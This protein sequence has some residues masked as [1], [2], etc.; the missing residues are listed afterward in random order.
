MEI[1][2]LSNRVIGYAIEINRELNLGLLK[3]TYAQCTEGW[4]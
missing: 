2:A 1:D 4:K 3:S